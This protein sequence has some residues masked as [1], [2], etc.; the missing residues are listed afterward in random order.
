MTMPDS[1]ATTAAQ[2]W[3]LLS[4]TSQLEVICS[5]GRTKGS[6]TRRL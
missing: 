2:V 4:A 3:E 5:R 1:R 6:S